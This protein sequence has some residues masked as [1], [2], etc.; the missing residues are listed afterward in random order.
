MAEW[1]MALAC[2]IV[3]G[4]GARSMHRQKMMADDVLQQQ[5][6]S[7]SVDGQLLH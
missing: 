6:S 5:A 1:R 4:H 3:H 7:H 2:M